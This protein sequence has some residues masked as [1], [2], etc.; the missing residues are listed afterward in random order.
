MQ[1]LLIIPARSGS[2]RI[3]NKN[4]KDFFGKPLIAHVIEKALECDFF[5]EVMV[6][7]DSEAN[8][9]LARQLGADV[10]FLRST[11]NSS[12]TATTS[13]VLVEVVSDYL[14]INRKF[15]FICCIYP[16]SV[17]LRM[18]KVKQ[19]FYKLIEEKCDSVISVIKYPHPIERAIEEK[20][21]RINF[22]FPEY[23]NTR[24][25]DLE[26][27]YFDAGQFYWIKSDYLL[28]AEKLHSAN[29]SSIVLEEYETQD[30]DDPSQWRLAE[31][32][33][34]YLLHDK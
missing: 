2:K 11:E 4:F 29:T 8:A 20:G 16:T 22:L 17:L 23:M 13:S 9:S 12:D 21:N 31:I 19:G 28:K 3:S 14:K 7:T 24:T 18:E 5:N 6:S 25:Q 1:K 30:I 32:K 27:K 26:D 10:P 33:F 15:D 34:K